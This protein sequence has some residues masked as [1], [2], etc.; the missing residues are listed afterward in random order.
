[1]SL[2]PKRSFFI[3]LSSV[4]L[5]LCILVAIVILGNGWLKGKSAQLHAEKLNLLL[6]DEQ[7]IA[8]NRAQKDIEKYQV[9]ESIANS[10]VPKDKDQARSVREIS[11]LANQSGVPI[12]SFTFQASTLGRTSKTTKTPA[13]GDAASGA[14]APA[15]PSITQATPVKGMKGV[16]EMAIT[17]QSDIKRPVPYGSLIQF[18]ELLEKNRRTAQVNSIEITPDSNSPELLTLQLG[19]NV[20]I[21]P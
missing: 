10:I 7:Q 16:Y 18:L 15:A 6:V 14:T 17:V 12:S 20:F 9:I 3:M 2:T 21:K 13:E 19:I 1:M 8:V 5:L 11:L 4:L